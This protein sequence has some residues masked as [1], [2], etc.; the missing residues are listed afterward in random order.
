VIG[1]RVAAIGVL[2][3]GVAG[4][5]GLW[6]SM[7]SSVAFV[8]LLLLPG[9]VLGLALSEDDEH[10]GPQGI[11]IA[12]SL[13]VAVFN[14]AAAIAAATA[15]SWPVFLRIF[16]GL[17][18]CVAALAWRRTPLAV[19]MRRTRCGYEWLALLLVGAALLPV[20]A[21]YA[22][23]GVDDWWDLAYVR[24][25]SERAFLDFR[26]PMLGT[27][28]VHPRFSWSAWVLLQAAGRE[29]AGADPFHLQSRV[30]APVVCIGSVSAVLLLARAVF[31]TANRLTVILSG[32]AATAWI[33][34]TD[35]LPYFV[36]LHQD[37]FFAALVLM[38]VL[39]ATAL[40]YIARPTARR[41]AVVALSAM[42]LCSVHTLVFG[43][44]A[45]GV[46][47]SAAAAYCGSRERRGWYTVRNGRFGYRQAAV[48][49]AVL[50]LTSIPPVWQAWTLRDWFMNQGVALA[51]PDNPVVRAH[52]ALGRL[53]A[54]GTPF[55]VVNPGAIFGPIG[56]VAAL[57]ACLALRRKRQGDAYL[58]ALTLVPAA[59][60][61]LPLVAAGIGVVTVPWMLYR[62]GWLI[63]QPLLL[64]RVFRAAVAIAW[65]P[66]RVLAVAGCVMVVVALSVP[67]AADRLRRGMRE[68][69]FS[70]EV[71]PRGTTLAAYRFLDRAESPGVVLAPPGFS[72]LIP[73]MTGRPVVAFSERGTLV[74]AGSEEA[75]YSRL[76]DRATFFACTTDAVSRKRIAEKYGVAYAVFR[77]RYRTAG[78]DMA[79]LERATADGVLLARD[80]SLPIECA[81]SEERLLRDLP[82]GWRIAYANSDYYVVETG[83]L[84]DAV[85][86]ER[87][88]GATSG[89]DS[90]RASGHWFNVIGTERADARGR[91]ELLASATAYPGG[92]VVL[93][94]VPVG[95]GISNEILWAGGGALWDD[96][97]V[98]VSVELRLRSSCPVSSIEV[99][100][101]METRRREAFEVRVEDRV[102]SVQAKDG[103]PIRIGLE[104]RPRNAVRVGIRSRLGLPF[105]ISDVRLF[106]ERAGCTGGWNPAPRPEF[107]G[108]PLPLAS[109]F[110]FVSTYPRSARAAIDLAVGVGAVTSVEDAVATLRR[111]IAREPGQAAAWIELGLRYDA[112]GRF[113]E[114]L[115]A[116][117]QARDVDSNSAWAHGCLAW[118][119]LRA[120]RRFASLWHAWRA[121][122]LDA[123]YA[124]AMT[125][126]GLA[127]ERLGS[128][129]M[130]VRSLER[131]IEMAPRRGWPYLE[132]ARQ[133]AGEGRREEAR[134]LLRRYRTLVPDDVAAT[135]MM[136][137]L[138]VSASTDG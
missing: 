93:N 27:G 75:A 59:V 103:R 52:L 92:S 30:I 50:V 85:G 29:L 19:P 35:A 91:G 116:Y 136:R 101:Y 5:A 124:D 32:F 88:L 57:G 115:E 132:R 25:L 100:P 120:G 31:T 62:I 43:I 60:L 83:L 41:A 51:M 23:G 90:L 82:A 17:C 2:A 99:V 89:S 67:T 84:P 76:S 12:L 134:A 55:M 53:I 37:K 137:S 135:E 78:D 56:L 44:G 46:L 45:L 20:V 26:E 63:P 11:A 122:R 81:S 9:Y 111:G 10:R 126:A 3:F 36:R 65:R 112:M 107:V 14:V 106:G 71:F 34:G 102:R 127:W 117:R 114:A 86:Q 105:G 18:V 54:A 24:A 138:A 70:Q 21:K 33:Y 109:Y 97:P 16:V 119:H 95:L 22:G 48:L 1:P 72:N 77:R 123:R 13:S 121:V 74:F 110:A 8:G 28:R 131:A 87:L 47:A 40:D 15:S 39:L 6:P 66:L 73:A 80:A 38:P 79:W 96:G 125:I 98:E 113:E 42:A 64:A 61:F 49:A 69:P 133:L 68:H 128:D 130:S 108:L 118:A 4:A 129:F 58:L 94:P 104:P 7:G